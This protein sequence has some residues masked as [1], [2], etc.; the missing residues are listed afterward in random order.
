V[1]ERSLLSFICS[2]FCRKW[3]KRKGK[4][5]CVEICSSNCSPAGV[6]RALGVLALHLGILVWKEL[7]VT[8]LGRE[9]P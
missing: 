2:Q 9:V 7:T 1:N 8:N 5:A 3:M 6:T 4:S